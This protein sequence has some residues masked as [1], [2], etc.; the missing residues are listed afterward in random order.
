MGVPGSC[1]FLRYERRR[2]V[3]GRRYHH[4]RHVERIEP[5]VWRDAYA[6]DRDALRDDDWARLVRDRAADRRGRRVPAAWEPDLYS[7][8]AAELAD[9]PTTATLPEHLI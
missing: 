7:E 3:R 5:E 8:V 1:W 4:H 9:G 6:T 2:A